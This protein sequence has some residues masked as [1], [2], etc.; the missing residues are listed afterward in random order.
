MDTKDILR[1]DSQI[2]ENIRGLIVNAGLLRNEISE[3]TVSHVMENGKMKPTTSPAGSYPNGFTGAG[4]HLSEGSQTL[5]QNHIKYLESVSM[6]VGP[7]D[8]LFPLASTGQKYS[9]DDLNELESDLIPYLD[10]NEF[11]ESAIRNFCW[12]LDK[13]GSDWGQILERAHTFSRYSDLAVTKKV[14]CEG[15]SRDAK[16]Y[17]SLYSEALKRGEEF[18]KN[19]NSYLFKDYHREELAKAL[20]GLFDRHWKQIVGKINKELS[21]KNVQKR[22]GISLYVDNISIIPPQKKWK[23]SKAGKRS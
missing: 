14:V 21:D 19:I 12:Q 16:E 15:L 1:I 8:P 9:D 11:R 10:F 6:P 22:I 17:D 18:C 5:L 4:M 3:L 2:H 20:S 23:K 7:N 13:G